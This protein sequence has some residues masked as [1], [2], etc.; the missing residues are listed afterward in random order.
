MLIFLGVFPVNYR[1]GQL[2]TLII[3]GKWDS[4]GIE[5][6]RIALSPDGRVVAIGAST[7]IYLYSAINAEQVARIPDAHNGTNFR[8]FRNFS[9]LIF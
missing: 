9:F 1:Q 7:S 2:A 8:I 6:A 3:S 4:A 5:K